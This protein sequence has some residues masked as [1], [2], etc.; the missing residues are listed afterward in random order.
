[1]SP[2]PRSDHPADLRRLAR[3]LAAFG[4]LLGAAS[5][6]A[7]APAA[8]PLVVSSSLTTDDLAHRW[9]ERFAAG[10]GG[11]TPRIVSGRYPTDALGELIAGRAAAALV[12]REPYPAELAAARAAG[13]GRLRF[14]PLAT[15]SRAQ[16]GGTHAIAFV[17]HRDNPLDALGLDQL[18]ELLAEDG[19]VRRWGDLG[20][21]GPLAERDIVVHGQPVLRPTGSPPGIV[22]FLAGRVLDGRAWRRDLVAHEDAPAGATALE[23]IVQAVARDP[24]AIGWSGFDYVVPGTKALALG[25]RA[26]GPFLAGSAEEVAERRY[27]LARA[28]YLCLPER[29]APAAQAFA[30]FVLEAAAQQAIAPSAAGFAPLPEPLRAATR[31]ALRGEGFRN[32]EGAIRITGYNDMREMVEAWTAALARAQ[33]EFRFALDLQ[34]TRTAV[35]A[36]ASGLAAFGPLGAE[37]SAA[38]RA[39]FRE[40]AGVE[41]LEVRV[42]HASLSPSALSGPVAVFVHESSALRSISLPR[43]AALFAGGDRTL[44]L[45][46][47]GLGPE[48]ALGE[49]FAARVL[50]GRRFAPGFTAFGQSAQVVDHVSEHPGAIGFAAAMRGRPGVRALAVA[51]KEGDPAV[52][53]A[54]E[55]LVDHRYP[56][57]RHLLLLARP[58]LDEWQRA[59]LRFVL[60]DDG[61]RLLAAGRLGYLPLSAEERAAEARR[62]EPPRA[63]SPEP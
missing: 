37:L 27:P 15:G 45:E 47:C 13:L 26:A 2:P 50:P 24:A 16:R 7:E 54:A 28:V 43:L 57:V 41:P 29:P 30:E 8:G 14:W 52:E 48:T 25:E 1:M 21:T 22:N 44:G 9:A 3:L 63:V 23:A 31:A 18:R 46:P 35:D 17:V 56:L 20:V 32:A 12:A 38:Q 60:S 33:P 42:A 58:P 10:P 5:V 55:N 51:E 59:F 61:Q 4:L 19:A 62:L 53:L 36:V 11:A 40:V 39:R 49:W 6:R 34:G